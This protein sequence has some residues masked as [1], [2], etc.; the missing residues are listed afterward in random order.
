MPGKTKES[1]CQ[2]GVFTAKHS[3]TCGTSSALGDAGLDYS[4]PVQPGH[5]GGHQLESYTTCAFKQKF[6]ISFL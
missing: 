4:K 3:R 1:I 5:P 2:P 6:V